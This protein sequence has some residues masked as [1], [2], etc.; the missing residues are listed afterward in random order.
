MVD[1]VVV[2]AVRQRKK[3]HTVPY[4]KVR[5]LREIQNLRDIACSS[6]FQISGVACSSNFR[7]MHLREQPRMTHPSGASGSNF[8][9]APGPAQFQ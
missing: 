8:E 6:N 3:Y 2:S 7:I 9:A 5:N 1:E 4:L